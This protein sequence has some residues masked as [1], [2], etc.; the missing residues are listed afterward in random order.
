M[1]GGKVKKVLLVIGLI[2]VSV[3]PAHSENNRQKEQDEHDVNVLSA[4]Q[5]VLLATQTEV[6]NSNKPPEKGKDGKDL[7]Q[8]KLPDEVVKAYVK[9]AKSYNDADEYL[10]VLLQAKSLNLDSKYARSEFEKHLE[11]ALK[12]VGVLQKVKGVQP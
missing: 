4:I 6:N 2:M 5:G 9:A 8:V 7:P 3:L 10:K 11:V 12:D 1:E